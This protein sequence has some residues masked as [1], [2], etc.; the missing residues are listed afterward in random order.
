MY[1]ADL[2]QCL[3]CDN[4]CNG[5]TAPLDNIACTSCADGYVMFGGACTRCSFSCKTCSG[6]PTSC[7]SCL[8]SSP[9]PY[10]ENNQCSRLCE[11]GSYDDSNQCQQCNYN[12]MECDGSKSNQCSK[13]SKGS[14]VSTT[15]LG[16]CLSCGGSCD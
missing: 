4:S 9:K 1:F 13:C 15:F 11:A 8:E 5:C 2:D 10:Y 6:S 16:D 3:S 7:T 12:C 14:Y